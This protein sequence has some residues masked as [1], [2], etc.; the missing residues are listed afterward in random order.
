M[1]MRLVAKVKLEILQVPDGFAG[2]ELSARRPRPA[3]RAPGP[4]DPG[5][6]LLP[7]DTRGLT[8]ISRAAFVVRLLVQ[9][10]NAYVAQHGVVLIALILLIFAH[11]AELPRIRTIVVTLAESVVPVLEFCAVMVP[12][13][14][15]LAV[16]GCL[17]VGG[18][19]CDDR[20]P[21]PTKLPVQLPPSLWIP[22]AKDTQWHMH[23]QPPG[24]IQ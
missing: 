20:L 4:R 11:L 24:R 23:R 14:L 7:E 5:R 12:V 22:S 21:P 10:N 17:T 8:L 18:P 16:S 19:R 9:L 3:I 2:S 15:C 6:Y 13:V 1:L